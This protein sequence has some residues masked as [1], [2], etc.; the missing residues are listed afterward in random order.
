MFVL[1]RIH[2]PSGLASERWCK[3]EEEEELHHSQEEQA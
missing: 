1:F 3:E 2:S